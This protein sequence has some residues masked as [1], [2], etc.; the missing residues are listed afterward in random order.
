MLLAIKINRCTVSKKK[1]G[2]SDSR[3]GSPTDPAVNV[4]ARP[5]NPP[6]FANSR[7]LRYSYYLYSMAC[8]IVCGA[9]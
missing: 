4:F 8:K 3:L 6:E 2:Q 9:Q 1:A 7:Q 5:L